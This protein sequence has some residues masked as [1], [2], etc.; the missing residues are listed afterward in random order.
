M[1]FDPYV[2]KIEHSWDSTSSLSKVTE[3]PFDTS[4]GISAELML[5]FDIEALTPVPLNL[6]LIPLF[7]VTSCP[8]K[9]RLIDFVIAIL[10]LGVKSLAKV[11]VS[12]SLAASI[13]S[14]NEVY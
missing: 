6:T 1:T 14:S 10:L 8:P 2:A 11:T 12:P 4:R 7:N 3:A 5:P 13:A 9:S